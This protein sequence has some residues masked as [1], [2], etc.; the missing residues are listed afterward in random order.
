MFVDGS[1]AYE[2]VK[3]DSDAAFKIVKP[4]GWVI[5]HDYNDG[6]FWP[7]VRRYLRELGATRKI[8]RIKGTMLAV[9]QA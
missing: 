9:C 8:V 5:W 2:Y 4:G 7:E 3:S 1:H 6:F